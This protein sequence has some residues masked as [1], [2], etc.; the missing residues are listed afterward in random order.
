MDAS[1][2]FSSK[3]AIEKEEEEKNILKKEEKDIDKV[4]DYHQETESLSHNT[5]SLLSLEESSQ[6]RLA[7][8]VRHLRMLLTSFAS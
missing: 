8:Y 5:N 4:T 1:N 2:E 3:A 6:S 7:M